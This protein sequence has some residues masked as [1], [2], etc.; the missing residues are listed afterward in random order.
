MKTLQSRKLHSLVVAMNTNK[1]MSLQ[2]LSKV[3]GISLSTTEINSMV[4][5][6]EAEGL[7]DIIEISPKG[8]F[9]NLTENGGKYSHELMENRTLV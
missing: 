7:M 4:K 8:T 5:D 1:K 3:M 2:N 9:A 6:F